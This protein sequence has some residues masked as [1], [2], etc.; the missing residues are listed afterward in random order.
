[1]DTLI[2]FI[3]SSAG[4]SWIITK[5]I[6][7]KGLRQRISRI[8]NNYIGGSV[9]KRFHE[10]IMNLDYKP[11]KY[12]KIIAY[13]LWLLDE[14]LNCSGCMGFWTGILFCPDHTTPLNYFKHGCI[15]AISALILILYSDSDSQLSPI[16]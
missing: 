3:L 7:F 9:E 12:N 6:I 4:L 15:S 8:F 16:K 10:S 2:K 1:M 11:K 5:S 14:L 13:A